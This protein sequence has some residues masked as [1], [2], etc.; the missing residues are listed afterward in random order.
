MDEVQTESQIKPVNSKGC[1]I[2]FVLNSLI[3]CQFESAWE[4]PFQQSGTMVNKAY[5][6]LGMI[7]R[8][9]KCMSMELFCLLY[10]LGL[11]WNTSTQFWI[12]NKDIE[13]IEK[14]QMRA[15]KLVESVKHLSYEHR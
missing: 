5:A 15:T 6:R 9:F 13:I 14:V 3:Q 4:F 1:V 11:N 2:N 7:K 12:L 10:G 8:N